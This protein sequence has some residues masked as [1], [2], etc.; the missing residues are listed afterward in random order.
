MTSRSSTLSTGRPFDALD[1]A[2]LEALQADARASLSELARTLSLSQPA[3]SQRVRKLEEAGVIRGYHAEVDPA[4]L[5]IGIH[6]IVRLRTTHA[7]L[8]AA[9]ERFADVPEIV[10]VHRM[11]GEDCFLLHVRTVDALRLE[12]VV[13]SVA[14]FGPV[15]TSLVLREYPSKPIGAD[16]LRTLRQR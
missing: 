16:L 3:I 5:G 15:T 4:A 14:R 10:S 2:I 13:D 9:L 12:A 6:A 1:V 8:A 7:H 11:T